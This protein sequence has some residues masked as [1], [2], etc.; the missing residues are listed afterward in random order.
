MKDDDTRSGAVLAGAGLFLVL[1]LVSLGMAVGAVV[2]AF[3][4][5]LNF[6][7]RGVGYM[8]GSLF[9]TAFFGLPGVL[10]ARS[11]WR[12]K[13]AKL[14]DD[15]EPSA[16]LVEQRVMPLP[17]GPGLFARWVAA[18]PLM[19]LAVGAPFVGFAAVTAWSSMSF[20][21]SLPDFGQPRDQPTFAGEFTENLGNGW[22]A[23]F[24]P[25]AVLL[26]F[27]VRRTRMAAWP[28]AVL[29][30]AG[31]MLIPAVLIGTV[32]SDAMLADLAIAVGLYWLSYEL[33]RAVVRI[34]SRPVAEDL[35]ESEL[36]I[37]YSLPGR[38]IRL[39]LQRDRLVLDRLT[40]DKEGT[41]RLTMGWP[42]VREVEL[43]DQPKELSWAAGP[44]TIE[45][46]AG[47]VLRIASA[48]QKWL[49][50]VPEYLGESLTSVITLRAAR[51]RQ[52]V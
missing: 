15:W 17:E 52:N 24:L 38:R 4:A 3:G 20:G 28:M 46:P 7:G 19:V 40:T 32:S 25:A 6:D 26:G 29:W 33:A 39:R 9:G 22:Q 51:R 44:A 43:L 49:I 27:L 50:P 13:P 21:A 18:V 37:P 14:P 16:R 47:P 11:W 1:G 2:P 36:E 41:K 45:V 30:V 35:V 10:L 8:F 42:D 48:E 5:A 34:L 23:L 31:W 12:A